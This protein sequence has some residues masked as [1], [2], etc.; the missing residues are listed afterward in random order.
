MKGSVVVVETILLVSVLLATILIFFSI[1]K[2][3][4]TFLSS[5]VQSSAEIVARDLAIL[6]SLSK[7]AKYAN[8][9][10]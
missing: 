5:I 8:I 1:P 6:S 2:L 7:A 9:T 4:E 3:I 10:Y